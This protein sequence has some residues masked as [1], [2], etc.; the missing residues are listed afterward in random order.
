MSLTTRPRRRATSERPDGARERLAHARVLLV[1]VGGLGTPAALEL[2]AAGVGTLGLMDGDAVELSNL[3]RQILYRTADVGRRKVVA[4]AERL[5]ARYPAVHVETFDERL[6]PGN[7]AALFRRFDFVIDA[8]DGIGSKYLVNDGAV[9]VGVPYSH[10]GVVAFQGQTMTVIPRR[11]A[12]LRCLFPLPPVAGEVPTCQEA[13]IAAPLPGS[14]GALQAAEAI[15]CLLG[16]G[17]LLTNRLVTYDA[18]QGRWR[19]VTVRHSPDCPVCGRTPSIRE[20]TDAA[21]GADACQ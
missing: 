3:Q 14:L 6:R 21:Y 15:K 9:I 13:G 5:I 12:C 2:A 1:G 8:T 18:L 4:A 11:S 20:L 17:A 7:L 10:A 16:V 19:T